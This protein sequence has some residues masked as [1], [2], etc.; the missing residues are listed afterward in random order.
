M[1]PILMLRDKKNKLKSREKQVKLKIKNLKNQLGK[2][3]S[4]K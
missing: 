4:G 2:V 1:K 3:R